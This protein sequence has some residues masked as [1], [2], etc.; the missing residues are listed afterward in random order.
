MVEG[1]R[2]D[3]VESREVIFVRRVVAVPGDHVER[4]VVDGRG[5]Q[6]PQKFGDDVEL[7]VAILKGR[8]RRLEIARIRQP[9]GAD[10]AQFRQPERQ[11]VVLADVAAS[12]FLHAVPR[13]T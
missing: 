10:R 4:R 12:L 7:A 5:P 2:V 1:N 8:H 13:G 11:S 9:V 3:A 6:P